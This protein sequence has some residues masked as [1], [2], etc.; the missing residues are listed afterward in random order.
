MID[1]VE[2]S[3]QIVMGRSSDEA[4]DDSK[5][6]V[7]CKLMENAFWRCQDETK[8]PMENAFQRCRDG[9]KQPGLECF[10]ID[11]GLVGSGVAKDEI[12]S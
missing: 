11:V 9:T 6:L 12:A 7:G 1:A 10:A 4:V 8:Q 3:A 2:A 5:E